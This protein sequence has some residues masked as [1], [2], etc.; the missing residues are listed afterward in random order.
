[1]KH[2]YKPNE[3]MYTSLYVVSHCRNP[4]TS[5]KILPKLQPLSMVFHCRSPLS[6][7]SHR[8]SSRQPLPHTKSPLCKWVHWTF[9]TF[10]ILNLDT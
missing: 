3:T 9:M 5:P 6:M 10:Q 2:S 1:M 4:K 8:R 7:V